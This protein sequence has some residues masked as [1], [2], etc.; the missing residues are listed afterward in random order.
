[1]SAVFSIF[2]GAIGGFASVLCLWVDAT[3][4]GAD[5]ISIYLSVKK[6]VDAWNYILA[7]NVV[8]LMIAG[9]LFGWDQALY[10]IIFQYVF[11]IVIKTLYHTYQQQTLF[12]V[13]R[14]PHKVS[15]VIYDVSRHGATILNGIGSYE[16][17][18]RNVVYSIVSRGETRQVMDAVRRVDPDALVNSIRTERLRGY[19]YQKPTQ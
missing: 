13:T 8:I 17:R 9:L 12:I 2:G 11:T 19:F 16:Q 3:A 6:G 5:F 14:E 15:Q 10:S 7:F 18:E 4:G 1:M